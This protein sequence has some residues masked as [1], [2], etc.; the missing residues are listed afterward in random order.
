MKFEN[1]IKK[2]IF[3]IESK[4]VKFLG[5][6]LTEVRAKSLNAEICTE[7]YKMVSTSQK[8]LSK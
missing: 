6:N 3:I 2:T 7:Q 4:K 1:K 8:S 5:I